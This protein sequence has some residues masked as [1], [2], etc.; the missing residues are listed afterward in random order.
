MD[1]NT[2]G[3]L[4]ITNSRSLLTL[5]GVHV[6]P[7]SWSPLPLP[8]PSHPSRLSQSTRF[9]LPASDSKF[10]TGILILHM[11]TYMFQCYFLSSSH[12]WLLAV[13]VVQSLSCVRLFA[14]PWTAAWQ[15]SPPC[16]SLTPW[17]CSNSCPLSQWCHPTISPY[18]TPFS[19]TTFSSC[20]Q[21]G[22][23]YYIYLQSFPYGINCSLVPHKNI[24]L[25]NQDLECTHQ[26]VGETMINQMPGN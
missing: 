13:V 21:S 14:T 12:L 5:M 16:R 3:F 2:P 18:V 10:F 4:S 15:A 19:V 23:L 1:C 6:S 22:F 7:P 24:I 8:T 17:V 20:P 9:E 25:W 11:V 26:L